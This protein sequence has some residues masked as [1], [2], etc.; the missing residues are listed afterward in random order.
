MN[1]IY[2]SLVVEIMKARRS[3]MPLLT[4]LAFSLVPFV[5][6][7]FMIIM[8]DPELARRL[9]IISAKAQILAGSA[10]W[11]TYLGIL[12]QAVAVGG[13]ILFAFIGSWVFGREYSDHTLKDLLALP[14]SRSAIVLSK[15]VLIILWSGLLTLIMCLIGLLVGMAVDLPPVQAE[16]I[17]QGILTL[18]VTAL[19]NIAL[20]T[21][22]AFFACAGGG[23]LPPIGVA[24][25]VLILAQVITAIGWGEYFP[26]AVPA[27]RAGMAGP[28]Y[29]N[30]GAVS[31]T[32]LFFVSLSGLLGTLIWWEL[33][34]QTN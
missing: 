32:I 16:V 4:G 15:F 27:L 10:D 20:I 5:G 21:P 3:K 7:F 19:L 1:A 33:A 17:R 25:L 12:A 14:T 22:I 11:E 23:Y 24:I 18:L 9:G 8:K 13:I 6:G 29:T 26:W 2:H 28:Q 31:Y 34:D 30:L